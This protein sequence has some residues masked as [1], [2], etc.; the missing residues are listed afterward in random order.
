[1]GGWVV[2]CVRSNL[3]SEQI[4]KEH[5]LGEFQISLSHGRKPEQYFPKLTLT[6]H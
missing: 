5:W 3:F 6:Q 4:E 2:P 1:M